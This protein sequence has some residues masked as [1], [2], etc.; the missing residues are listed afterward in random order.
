MELGQ[1]ERFQQIKRRYITG[2]ARGAFAAI[3]AVIIAPTFSNN[4]IL[5]TPY[6]QQKPGGKS[7]K[8][9]ILFDHLRQEKLLMSIN[10]NRNLRI[11]IYVGE[12]DHVRNAC[13]AL[14]FW[15]KGNMENVQICEIKDGNH[16]DTFMRIFGGKYRS[17]LRQ[18]NNQIEKEV[19]EKRR[20]KPGETI[21]LS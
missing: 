20:L 18:H 6:F 12:N 19:L 1:C 8:E 14:C 11:Q 10:K 17:S 4:V 5:A 7:N 21:R 3:D 9:Q 15:L 2:H 16:D 13:Y